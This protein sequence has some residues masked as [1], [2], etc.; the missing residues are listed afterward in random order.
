VE[1]APLALRA[2]GIFALDT[3]SIPDIY[4]L[5]GLQMGAAEW[6]RALIW[7]PVILICLLAFLVKPIPSKA[8]YLQYALAFTL[9]ALSQRPLSPASFYGLW[10]IGGLLSLTL[11]G[12]ES[13]YLHRPAP[14]R[15]TL[16]V[17]LAMLLEF[18]FLAFLRRQSV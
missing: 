7:A 14:G 4:D 10:A 1:P 18:I 2:L 15:F 13:H 11:A 8:C 6:L 17:M 12:W 5:E 3:K 9:T 16:L